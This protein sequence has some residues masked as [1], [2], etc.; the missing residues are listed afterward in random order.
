M[1]RVGFYPGTR[2]VSTEGS[3]RKVEDMLEKYTLKIHL[4]NC[5]DLNISR[6]LIT[7]LDKQLNLIM[8]KRF[9]QILYQIRYMDIMLVL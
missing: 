6:A 8:K 5:L 9:E 7:Q 3:L 2:W 1:M 4:A